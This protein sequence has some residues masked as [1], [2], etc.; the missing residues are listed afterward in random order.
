MCETASI[1]AV[2]TPTISQAFMLVGM[3][4]CLTTIETLLVDVD[5]NLVGVGN[6]AFGILIDASGG[7]IL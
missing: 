5:F 6:L 2:V 1:C 7:I 4:G 3:G